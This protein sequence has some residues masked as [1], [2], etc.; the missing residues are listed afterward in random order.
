MAKIRTR[1]RKANALL[2]ASMLLMVLCSVKAQG[3][4]AGSQN[5]APPKPVSST[6]LVIQGRITTIHGALVTVKT[7]DAYPGGPGIHPQ[8]VIGGP[9]FQVDI[10]RAR[11][12]LPDGSRADT[13][14]L[15]VGDRVLMVLSGPASG[16]PEPS[17]PG[18]INQTYF[19]S[20]IE[21]IVVGDKIITH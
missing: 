1:T 20:T 18:N 19:A 14:P 12:L 16:P 5:Q 17:H 8:F 6:P 15:A 11:V 10:S 2:A 3:V 13:Q 21:R 7:P 9:A 4:P